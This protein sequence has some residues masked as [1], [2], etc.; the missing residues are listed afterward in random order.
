MALRAYRWPVL[1]ATLCWL[2]LLTGVLVA[3]GWISDEGRGEFLTRYTIRIALLFYGGAAVLMPWF[4]APDWS[5]QTTW[6]RL[7]RACWTFGLLAYLVHLGMAF[8]FYHH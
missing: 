1:A 5:A 6:G 7:A 4:V 3:S 8:H 2:L